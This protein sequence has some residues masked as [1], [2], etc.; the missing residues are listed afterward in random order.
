M[1]SKFKWKTNYWIQFLVCINKILPINTISMCI[2][3][4]LTLKWSSISSYMPSLFI[5]LGWLFSLSLPF[6]LY[7]R[8]DFLFFSFASFASEKWVQKTGTKWM[9]YWSIPRLIY[10]LICAARTGFGTY[11]DVKSMILNGNRLGKAF[12]DVFSC[13]TIIVICGKRHLQK[14][15]ELKNYKEAEPNRTELS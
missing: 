3:M 13:R 10:E 4:H 12:A 2:F 6:S 5:Y 7:D 11:R 1:I 9:L 14:T 8:I 15:I